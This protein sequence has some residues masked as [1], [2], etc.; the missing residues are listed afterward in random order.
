[1]NHSKKKKTAQYRI[2]IILNYVISFAIEKKKK[3]FEEFVSNHC[4]L[5]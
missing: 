1:M 4:N 3:D 5:M 2:I